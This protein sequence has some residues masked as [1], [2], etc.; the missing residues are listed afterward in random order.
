MKLDNHVYPF[1]RRKHHSWLE[2]V[3]AAFAA[4]LEENTYP[5]RYSIVDCDGSDAVIDAT[6]VR[7][8]SDCDYAE[9]LK[10]VEILAPR[11]KQFQGSD[12]GIVQIIPTG[13]RCEFGGYAGDACPATNLLAG[14][15]DFLITHPN[16]V[17]ASELNEMAG[18]VFYVEGHA[19][20]SFL[21]GHLGLLPV[22]SNTIG[23]FIDPTGNDFLDDVLNTL[24]AARAVKGVS[25]DLY[26]VL[27]ADL[28]VEIA[29][30]E[31]QCAVGTVRRPEVILDAVTRLITNGAQAIGGVSVIHGV[32]RDMFA[33]HLRGEIPNPSGG[34]EAIITHLISK[35]FR[36]P[37][38]HAPLPY[39]Q[40]IKEKGSHSPRASAEFISIPHYFSVLKGLA[41]A[42]RLMP[43][44]ALDHVPPHLHSLNDIGA[45]VMPADC[46]G[47][48]PA[49]VAEYNDIP[50]IAVRENKTIL[51]VTNDK[52]HMRN[53]IEV[54]SY[55][56]AAGV[57]IALRDGISLES[58]RRPMYLP[59]RIDSPTQVK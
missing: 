9:T 47:G 29:W 55:L 43:I 24:N 7:F 59:N 1:E 30:S 2:S 3:S 41:R 37:T 20:D 42:P 25:C 48:V 56:E 34:I 52:M 19:L 23:T 12:F 10:T 45:I 26:T 13:I 27:R 16:A 39:Y 36:L 54:E 8:D 21:L 38:A 46:L 15:A 11:K 32:T 57:V 4:Q 50:L 18:N 33:R 58:L 17:N 49:L 5:L 35:I 28:G 51:D 14:A 53:V 44:S 22:R 6:I 40:D 31:R